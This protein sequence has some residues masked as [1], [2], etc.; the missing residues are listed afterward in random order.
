MQEVRRRSPVNVRIHAAEPLSMESTGIIME[1]GFMKNTVQ[2]FGKF[3][4]AM[5]MPNIARADRLRFSG[6]ALY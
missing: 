3:L 6:R 4:S 5:V 1:E 2:R